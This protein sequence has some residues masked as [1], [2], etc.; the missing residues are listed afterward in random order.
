[1]LMNSVDQCPLPTANAST[2]VIED[3][4]INRQCLVRL[5][6]MNGVTVD[7]A[8]TLAEGLEKLGAHPRVV[9][10]DLDLPD[11]PGADVLGHIRQERMPVRVCVLTGIT[12]FDPAA[13]N[14]ATG[15][16][17][18]R[19]VLRADA[20]FFKPYRLDD[21]LGWVGQAMRD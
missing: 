18:L 20:V 11:G 7:S 14:E 19:S 3:D 12:E 17:R 8:A 16:G 1:M 6:R 2:L 13:P 9:L 15:S 5:L 21:I 4:L 10:L